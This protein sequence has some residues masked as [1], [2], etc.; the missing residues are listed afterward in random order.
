MG[1][2]CYFQNLDLWVRDS[3]W[4]GELRWH[5]LPFNPLLKERARLL[6][7]AGN[8][9]EAIF[10]SRVKKKQFLG[11][12][13]DRHKIIGNY[14]VDFYCKNLGIVIEIDGNSHDLKQEYD[15]QRD[16]YLKGL[17]LKVIHISD[18]EVKQNIQAVFDYLETLF[19]NSP[20]QKGWQT[21]SD[22]VVE[23]EYLL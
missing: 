6:R 10:W 3:F 11:L 12:D 13:F 1:C 9:A 4:E 8:L 5:D 19:K 7:R 18:S 17:G 14:I 22:G 23:P 15:E 16:A 21:E 20:S 2:F